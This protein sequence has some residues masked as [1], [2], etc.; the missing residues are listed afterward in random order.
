M[1]RLYADFVSGPGA[2]GLLFLRLVA[3]T[4]MVYHGLDKIKAPFNW[5]HGAPVPGFLQALAAL[6]EFGGGLALIVGL[7]T[8][9]ATLGIASTMFVAML[10]QFTNA[11]KPTYFVKPPDPKLPGDAY[12][13]AAIYFVIA[14]LLMLI[15]PGVLSLDAQLFGKNRRK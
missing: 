11:V 10:S 9:L 4:A 3:G 1:R 2:V 12:E 5:M 6:S 15:G 8:P 13:S 7:L 14:I